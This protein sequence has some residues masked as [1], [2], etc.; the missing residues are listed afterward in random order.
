MNQQEFSRTVSAN[1][2]CVDFLDD[3]HG[4]MQA[5][6][7]IDQSHPFFF[8]HP[9]DHVPGLLLIEAMNQLAERQ[10]YRAGIDEGFN[11][12]YTASAEVAFT[13]FCI[14][15]VDATVIAEAQEDARR[16]TTRV[17]QGGIVKC[18][19]V[20]ELTPFS[21]APTR[22]FA[23]QSQGEPCSKELLNKFNEANVM[24]STP[25]MTAHLLPPHSGNVL[26]D[27]RFGLLPTLY[28]LEAYM[29]TQRYLNKVFL[30]QNDAVR[31]RDTLC[32]VSI[33]LYRPIKRGEH[34]RIQRRIPQESAPTTGLHLHS[35]ELYVA[36]E[37]V[38]ECNIKTLTII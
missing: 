20:F 6:L 2:V 34:V 38:G 18:S 21:A 14:F 19:G 26:A 29:Q 35:G 36:D 32:G 16:I 3:Q 28:L 30:K 9:L 8:D 27:N 1:Q 33:R 24:I 5:R 4:A 11:A 13:K 10:A 22:Q 25:L 15:G 7:M 37:C 23:E 12:L 31:M 17:E